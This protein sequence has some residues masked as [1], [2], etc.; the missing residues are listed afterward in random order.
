[1]IF[2]LN[3]VYYL[4]DWIINA[5]VLLLLQNVQVINLAVSLGGVQSLVEHTA[6]MTHGPLIVS[7]ED[8]LAQRIGDGHIR[9]RYNRR[10]LFIW[11]IDV[12]QLDKW[13]AGMKW[14]LKRI[15]NNI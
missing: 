5:C 15:F 14:Q 13:T 11:F 10:F 4:N 1:M 2:V 12:L 8:R 9:L 7:D 6:S 3:D